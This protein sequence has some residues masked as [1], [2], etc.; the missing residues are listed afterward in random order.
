[1]TPAQAAA[2]L[3]VTEADVMAMIEDGSLKAKKL[4]TAY[5]IAKSVIDEFMAG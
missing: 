2:Y 5:R 1:M 3:Q 4:G